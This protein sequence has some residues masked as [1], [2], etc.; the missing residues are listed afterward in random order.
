MILDVLKRAWIRLETWRQNRIPRYVIGVDFGKESDAVCVMQVL[1]NGS[2][3]LIQL[4]RHG[5]M[6]SEPIRQMS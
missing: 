6:R 4:S 1:P 5:W 3:R 2:Y